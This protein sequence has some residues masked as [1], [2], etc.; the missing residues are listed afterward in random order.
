MNRFAAAALVLLVVS[1]S[2]II[3]ADRAPDEP[4]V[5]P[6][7]RPADLTTGRPRLTDEPLIREEPRPRDLSAPKTAAGRSTLAIGGLTPDQSERIA[8]IR[9]QAAQ[10]VQA[11][12]DR[13]R[14]QIM[15]VLSEEQ[16]AEYLKY[17]DGS[18]S[19]RPRSTMVTTTTSPTTAPF[20]PL[21]LAPIEPLNPAPIAR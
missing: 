3:G 17:E 16:R 14:A 7:P 11:V 8:V 4:P 2:A 21:P 10:E 5:R 9:Q 13:E 1:V 19:E 12:R 18:E 20:E 6:D 15:A